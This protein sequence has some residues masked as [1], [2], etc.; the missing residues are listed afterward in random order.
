MKKEGLYLLFGILLVMPI[1]FA[2]G[3]T[4]QDDQELHGTNLTFI[5]N[6]TTMFISTFFVSSQNR[7]LF[8]LSITA[9]KA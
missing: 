3:V 1:V 6:A 4:I 7:Y 8:L 9:P 5:I 2:G